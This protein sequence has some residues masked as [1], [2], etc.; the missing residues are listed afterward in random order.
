MALGVAIGA[1]G[2]HGLD[3]KISERM[4][5]NYQTGVHYH[6]VHGLGLI[7][8]GLFALKL[9][10]S[11]LVNGAGWAFLAGI[12]LFSGSLYVMALTGITKLGAITPI[13]GVAFIVGW[14]LLGL[15][16]MRHL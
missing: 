10:S 7:A 15:A 12:V 3:G 1:F 6:M 9:G 5:S 4:M 14:V 2:A 11:G 13:G 16:A 8:A